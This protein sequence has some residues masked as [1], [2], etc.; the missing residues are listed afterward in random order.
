M[1]IQGS[2]PGYTS[3]PPRSKLIIDACVYTGE[4]HG[5]ESE[6]FVVFA[7]STSDYRNIG[8]KTKVRWK[9]LVCG[10]T[11]LLVLKAFD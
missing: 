2:R 5:F 4:V 10:G 3:K 9:D 6:V 11:L 8:D 7:A 1:L